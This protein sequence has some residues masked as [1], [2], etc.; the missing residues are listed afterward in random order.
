ML[1][2]VKKVTVVLVVLAVGVVA[3]ADGP[4]LLP[5]GG[6]EKDADGDGVADGW[7]AHDQA[8]AAAFFSP[9]VTFT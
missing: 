9:E 4:N 5:N 1:H 6:F 7:V 2:I 8:F 3:R